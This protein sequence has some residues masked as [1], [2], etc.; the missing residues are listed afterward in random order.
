MNRKTLEIVFILVSNLNIIRQWNSELKIRNA[1]KTIIESQSNTHAII[2]IH[3]IRNSILHH[4]TEQLFQYLSK[5]IDESWQKK[6]T[7][8]AKYR[9]LFNFTSRRK[10]IGE[11]GVPS[12]ISWKYLLAGVVFIRALVFS[13]EISKCFE[14]KDSKKI[15]KLITAKDQ[16]RN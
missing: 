11:F 12:A 15:R 2:F 8:T 1:N 6:K 5:I 3:S 4:R 10:K 9:H 14:W 13:W 7:K 16:I